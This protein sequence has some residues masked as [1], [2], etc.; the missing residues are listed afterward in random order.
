[1]NQS[2]DDEELMAFA[3][4]AL[5]EPRFSEVAAAIET[6]PVLAERLALIVAGG[7]AA[8]A[9]F[10]PLADQPVPARLTAGVEAA[11]AAHEGKVVPFRRRITTFLPIAAAAAIAALA[12]GPVAYFAGGSREAPLEA[13]G[14]PL[15]PSITSLLASLPSGAEARLGD[16]VIR[17]IA[18][19]TDAQS[20]LCRE[21]ELDG[22]LTTVAVA[23]RAGAEWRVA[24]AIDAPPATDGYAPASSLAALD[25]FLGSI[26]AGPPLPPAAEAEALAGR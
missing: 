13:I 15:A 4:G 2:F 20:T 24:I 7:K 23:C 12:V 22:A 21:F 6:D 1:M 10:D 5:D 14:Q 16:A 25:A 9:V 26:D 18:T 17:P 3:D 8:E 11:I 19:F